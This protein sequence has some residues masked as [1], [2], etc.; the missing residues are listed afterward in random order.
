MDH[1]KLARRFGLKHEDAE[2]YSQ[3]LEVR[4]LEGKNYFSGFNKIIDFRRLKRNWQAFELNEKAEPFYITKDTFNDLTKS[5]NDRD[6]II[7]EYKFIGGMTMEE[8]G[9]ALDLSQGRISQ[10]FQHAIIKLKHD[11]F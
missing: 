9:F 5:L 6:K 10:L 11:L 2:D 3:W 7:M 8:I 1:Y 4:K